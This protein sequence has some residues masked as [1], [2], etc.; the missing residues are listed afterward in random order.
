VNYGIEFLIFSQDGSG[1]GYVLGAGLDILHMASL[2]IPTIFYYMSINH[3]ILQ[4]FLK[5]A[6]IM[7]AEPR[8]SCGIK[9]RS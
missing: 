4:I 7:G 2:V 3:P 6:N 5:P 9:A 8:Q 1:T